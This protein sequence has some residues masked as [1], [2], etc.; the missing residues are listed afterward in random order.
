MRHKHRGKTCK[1]RQ[2]KKKKKRQHGMPNVN[3]LL[4]EFDEGD[5]VH[6]IWDSS[7]TSGEP[8]RRFVGKT[9]TVLSK[10][11]AC[12]LVKIKD[13]RAEKKLILHPAHIR[14]SG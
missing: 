4:R 8:F 10:Q 13:M 1:T 5:K 12:Y 7:F 9:G 3:T 2:M 14:K 6:I 11:G